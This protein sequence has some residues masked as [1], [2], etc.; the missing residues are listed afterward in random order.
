MG[1]GEGLEA[2]L[3]AGR[4]SA[5]VGAR[6]FTFGVRAGPQARAHARNAFL[7][8]LLTTRA[9]HA[10]DTTVFFAGR[11]RILAVVLASVRTG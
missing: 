6:M 9:M 11:T 10:L 8:A 3:V 1:A 5:E 7:V 4:A 2:R